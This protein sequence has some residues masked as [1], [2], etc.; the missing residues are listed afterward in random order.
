MPRLLAAC[1]VFA[2]GCSLP[3]VARDLRDAHGLGSAHWLLWPAE[4]DWREAPA[5]LSAHV[6][7]P[8]DA[9]GT[10]IDVMTGRVL[11]TRHAWR[12]RPLTARDVR[13]GLRVARIE[14]GESQ[15]TMH[16]LG[17]SWTVGPI[18]ALGPGRVLLHGRWSP[19]E[20]LRMVV[21]P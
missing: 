14:M 18:E 16:S 17:S 7:L 21:E 20:E 9:R 12:S 2:L 11:R 5:L 19:I 8:L 6:A 13:V 15:C 4:D 3:F 1:L 10:F